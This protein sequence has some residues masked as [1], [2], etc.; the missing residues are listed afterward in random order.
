MPRNRI[1]WSEQEQMMAGAYA[2]IASSFSQITAYMKNHLRTVQNGGGV[3][4][5]GDM[6]DILQQLSDMINKNL[7]NASQMRVKITT[8]NVAPKKITTKNT[9]SNWVSTASNGSPVQFESK[10]PQKIRIS[11]S[12]L[13]QIITESV[14]KI[15]KEDSLNPYGNGYGFNSFQVE[16][17]ARD[18]FF[19]LKGFDGYNEAKSIANDPND[20]RLTLEQFKGMVDEW[21]KIA[22]KHNERSENNYT[23]H[24]Q[25]D[26]FKVVPDYNRE[27]EEKRFKDYTKDEYE[28]RARKKRIGTWREKEGD[29]WEEFYDKPQK[30]PWR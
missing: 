30:Q 11:E 1:Q 17:I 24:I 13:K 20:D 12:E 22:E 9:N 7:H 14:K 25:G 6:E 8:E 23:T 3:I 15:L 2:N 5:E 28:R 19:K 16:G 26:K 4:N 27:A 21:L 10:Q 18:K 29:R